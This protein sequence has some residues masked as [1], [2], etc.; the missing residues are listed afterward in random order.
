MAEKDNGVKIIVT[1]VERGQ[2]KDLLKIYAQNGVNCNLQ[3]IGRGTA[4]SELLDILGLGT[5]ERDILIS[6]AGTHTAEALMR[7]LNE[8]L[9]RMNA[10]GIAF[11]MGLTGINRRI[12]AAFM[13]KEEAGREKEETEKGEVKMQET[14]GN[15][16]LVVVNQGHTDEVMETARGAGARGGTVIRSRWA[17]TDESRQFYGFTIQEEKEII[18]IVTTPEHRNPI[19][20]IIN[21][22]H[23]L[24]T[25]A[26]AMICSMNIDTMAKLSQ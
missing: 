5:T 1:I 8:G 26:G 4:S 22:M 23:G 9:P 17:G 11:D 19:M 18:A 10:K 7:R 20:E 25:E 16:I 3:S 21:K 14:D 2:G 13:Q 6:L 15:L 12:A 24:Q